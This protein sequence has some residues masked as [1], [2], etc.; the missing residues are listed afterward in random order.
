MINPFSP[1]TTYP[2]DDTSQLVN[3]IIEIPKELVQNELDK[4]SGLLNWTVYFFLLFTTQPITGLFHKV[5]A[6]ITTLIF[7]ILSQIDVVPL[8]I[9]TQKSLEDEMMDGGEADDKIIAVGAK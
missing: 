7:L 9:C 1:G 6:M 4:E 3:I 8:C 2:G 5:T